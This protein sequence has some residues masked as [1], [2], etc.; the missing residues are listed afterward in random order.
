MTFWNLVAYSSIGMVLWLAYLG[1]GVTLLIVLKRLSK[2]GPQ[3]ALPTTFIVLAWPIVS[4]VAATILLIN[5][6]RGK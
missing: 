2:E 4:I 3:G 6:I 5:K 1:I